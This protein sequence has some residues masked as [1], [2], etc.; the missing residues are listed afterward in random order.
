MTVIYQD[1][2]KP[3]SKPELRVL[4]SKPLRISQGLKLEFG[5]FDATNEGKLRFIDPSGQEFEYEL[6][7]AKIIAANIGRLVGDVRIQSEKRSGYRSISAK[8]IDGSIVVTYHNKEHQTH[9]V[10]GRKLL[11]NC[12]CCKSLSKDT[13]MRTPER[14]WE[15]SWDSFTICT[16]CM[17][18]LLGKVGIRAVK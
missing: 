13:W 15:G 9:L 3:Q 7:Q 18:G 14:K 4:T 1:P 8:L 11:R 5:I 12:N 10:R 16:S 17:D 6:E 2:P